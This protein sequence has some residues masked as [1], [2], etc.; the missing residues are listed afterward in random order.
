MIQYIV[1]WKPFCKIDYMVS[2][3]WFVITHRIPSGYWQVTW[4]KISPIS[5]KVQPYV[6]WKWYFGECDL[7]L[8][9]TTQNITH[10]T[11]NA[12]EGDMKVIFCECA[13]WHSAWYGSV[14]KCAIKFVPGC[15]LKPLKSNAKILVQTFSHPN[16]RTT[17]TC[18]KTIRQTKLLLRFIYLE[19]ILCII[20][21]FLYKF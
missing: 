21:Q 12:A 3:F 9:L 15:Q 18:K 19:K 8:R 11:Q 14:T 17:L 10:I 1:K 2:D 6:I 7:L 13:V 5:H 4:A 20:I 16:L